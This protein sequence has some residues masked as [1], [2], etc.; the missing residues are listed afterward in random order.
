MYCRVNSNLQKFMIRILI[1]MALL[2]IKLVHADELTQYPPY[3]DVWGYDLSN[4]VTSIDKDRNVHIKGYKIESGDYWF[5]FISNTAINIKL[6]K[7]LKSK[8]SMLEFFGQRV[9]KNYQELDHTS[10][11]SNFIYFKE[12]GSDRVNKYA[13]R[14]N[15]ISNYDHRKITFSNGESLEFDSS[16]RRGCW[17][18]GIR[19]ISF[20]KTDKNGNKIGR[21]AIII[22]NSHATSEEWDDR[23][24]DLNDCGVDSDK[25]VLAQLHPIAGGMILL[26]DDTFLLYGSTSRNADSIIVRF[27]QDLTTPYSPDVNYKMYNGKTLT[28]KI[29]VIPYQII[30]SLAAQ[31]HRANQPVAQALQNRLIDF[32]ADDYPLLTK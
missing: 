11:N 32:L 1:I 17:D 13:L 10:V 26:K 30:A 20:L 8:Y 29:F 7:T 22:A 2:S 25:E 5:N 9:H 15:W 12:N 16:I 19:N 4:Y 14:D 28:K 18:T 6:D 31:A 21:Y 3:P 23:H 24:H 27:K